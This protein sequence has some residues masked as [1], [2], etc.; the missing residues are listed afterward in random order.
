MAL[1]SLGRLEEALNAVEMGLVRENENAP[2]L[3][4]RE[5][6]QKKIEEAK[7]KQVPQE[8]SKQVPVGGVDPSKVNEAEAKKNSGNEEYK[9]KNFSKAIDHYQQAIQINPNEIIYHSNVA[10]AHI[11]M[12][13]FD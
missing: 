9:K 1:E 11:E 12:K 13:Q 2:L 10:A 3:N 5:P 6:L 8:E 7:A 4:L